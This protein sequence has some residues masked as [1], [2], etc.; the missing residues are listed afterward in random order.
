MTEL[1]TYDFA[2]QILSNESS[3]KGYGVIDFQEF[4]IKDFH[5]KCEH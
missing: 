2:S 3:E 1:C 5:P 4:R